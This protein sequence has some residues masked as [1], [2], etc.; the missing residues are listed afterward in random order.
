MAEA[1]AHE[2][3]TLRV[4]DYHRSR[5]AEIRYLVCMLD[6]GVCKLRCRRVTSA[7]TLQHHAAAA[8]FA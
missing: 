5:A 6:I 4:S 2:Y 3:R 8:L 7:H 1:S